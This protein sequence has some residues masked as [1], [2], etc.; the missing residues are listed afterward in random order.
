MPPRAYRA[1]LCRPTQPRA[2][3][4]RAQ[5]PDK[6]SE[7]C[8]KD[9]DAFER[10]IRALPAG[11][12]P[13]VAEARARFDAYFGHLPRDGREP[14]GSGLAPARPDSPDA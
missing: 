12:P 4:G 1:S 14:F 8:V 11:G 13:A 10:A 7:R 6:I 2:R 5:Y 9:A 3:P